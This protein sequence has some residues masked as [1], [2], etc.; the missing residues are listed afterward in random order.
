MG[1]Y[2]V[3]LFT[4]LHVKI[5]LLVLKFKAK[6]GLYIASPVQSGILLEIC[7]HYLNNYEQTKLEL[8]FFSKIQC[9]LFLFIMSKIIRSPNI[10]F[11][12]EDYL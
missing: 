1:K 2:F 9:K 5:P 11:C 6:L 10:V 7:T 8:L 12:F 3:Q 4:I